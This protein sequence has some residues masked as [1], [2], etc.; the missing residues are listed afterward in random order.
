[1]AG[2]SPDEPELSGPDEEPEDLG[3][4][5]ATSTERGE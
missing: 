5:I 1:M 3:E 2:W 4:Y